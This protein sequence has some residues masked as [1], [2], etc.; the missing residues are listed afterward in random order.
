MFTNWNNNIGTR[1]RVNC[2]A[3]EMYKSSNIDQGQNNTSKDLK[4]SV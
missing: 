2:Q 1:H 3:P 4:I